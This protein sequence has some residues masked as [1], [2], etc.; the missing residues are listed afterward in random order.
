MR[1]ETQVRQNA[2]RLAISLPEKKQSRFSNVEWR[3]KQLVAVGEVF[4]ESLPPE[5]HPMYV[6]SLAGL[7]DDQI[8]ICIGRAVRELEWFP[9][10]AK[11]RELAG[12]EGSVTKQDA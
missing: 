3:I 7:S 11:L 8:R 4:K 2:G 6:E 10:P 5:R 1:M 9:K 12:A